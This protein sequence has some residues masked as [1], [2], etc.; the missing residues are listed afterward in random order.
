MHLAVGAVDHGDALVDVEDDVAAV[1]EDPVLQDL[2]LARQ[3]E[4]VEPREPMAPLAKRTTTASARSTAS[5]KGS[6]I[7]AT[8]T[9]VR[10]VS[11]NSS[12]A[13]WVT[14]VWP[15]PPPAIAGSA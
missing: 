8:L 7:A 5:S 15:W 11:R 2:V 14:C 13:L 1:A 10:P 4:P 9:G 12:A 6:I 3:T